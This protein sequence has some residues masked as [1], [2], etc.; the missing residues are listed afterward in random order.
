MAQIIQTLYS[1]IINRSELLIYKSQYVWNLNVDVLVMDELELS[2]V[3]QI[4]LA[5]RSAFQDLAL[6]QVIATLNANT[7]VIEVGLFEEV[8]PDKENT[9]QLQMIKTA[10]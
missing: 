10:G 4:A 2:Q 6:P 5:V 8:Y 3:D 9:D 7:N 1:N